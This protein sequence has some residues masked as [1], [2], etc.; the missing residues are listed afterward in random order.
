[1]PTLPEQF[2]TELTTRLNAQ[3]T[4]LFPAQNGGALR[5]NS[6]PLEREQRP[7]IRVD[8]GVWPT[9]VASNHCDMQVSGA[10]SIIITANSE[11][12]RDV[13]VNA[14][15]RALDHD[16]P[17]N[18]WP[19]K[20]LKATPTEIRYTRGGADATAFV[21]TLPINVGPFH[22]RKYQLDVSA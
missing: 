9:P 19:M 14:A 17:G 8:D 13:L 6:F 12:D 10:C 21:A 15:Y 11:A 3:V 7:G 18:A 2:L 20:I 5:G 22:V 1:M 4:T 16:A